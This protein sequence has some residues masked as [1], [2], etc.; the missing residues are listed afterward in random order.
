MASPDGQEGDE[1]QH[2]EGDAQAGE[3]RAPLV[4]EQQQQAEPGEQEQQHAGRQK[5]P[6]QL[7]NDEEQKTVDPEP[8]LGLSRSAALPDHLVAA[9]GIGIGV[10]V[11]R[12]DLDRADIADPRLA[13]RPAEQVEVAVVR[14]RSGS[15]AYDRPGRDRPYPS[16]RSIDRCRSRSSRPGTRRS[17]CVPVTSSDW[18][19]QPMPAHSRTRPEGGTPQ[20]SCADAAA[21]SPRTDRGGEDG[22][23]LVGARG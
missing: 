7:G 12:Q 2:A 3:A 20:A 1:G 4:P 9:G 16:P 10:G 5:E 19:W 23:R 21:V 17:I 15:A 8:W 6:K 22:S 11:R 13:V 18:P 14:S